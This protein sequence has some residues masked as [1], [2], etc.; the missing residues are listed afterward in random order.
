MSS[1]RRGSPTAQRMLVIGPNATVAPAAMRSAAGPPGNASCS[2]A[3]AALTLNFQ[4]E[5]PMTDLTVRRNPNPS[6]LDMPPMDPYRLVRD[7][8]RFDPFQELAP[9]FQSDARLQAFMPAFEV[10]ETPK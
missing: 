9:A 10:K 6:L 4:G 8:M 1:P 5:E 3:R 2:S 7:W